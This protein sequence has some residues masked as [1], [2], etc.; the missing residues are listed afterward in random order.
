MLTS[1]C[2]RCSDFNWKLLAVD[3]TEML[4]NLRGVIF[5]IHTVY[6][7]K[8]RLQGGLEQVNKMLK[9]SSYDESFDHI[10]WNVAIYLFYLLSVTMSGEFAHG[11]WSHHSPCS[12]A[13]DIV[14]AIADFHHQVDRIIIFRVDRWTSDS[15][16]SHGCSAAVYR[17]QGTKVCRYNWYSAGSL[18]SNKI[19]GNNFIYFL[20]SETVMVWNYQ[21]ASWLQFKKI[22]FLCHFL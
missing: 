13:S 19:Y 3:L 8:Q 10:F 16:D 6:T 15:T 12:A 4:E 5:L 22:N 9:V 20:H 17:S 2:N 1:K 18:V 21:N 7:L 11:S 14:A